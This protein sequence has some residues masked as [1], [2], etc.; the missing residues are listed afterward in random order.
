MADKT[1]KE[2]QEV[3]SKLQEQA[4]K[5]VVAERERAQRILKWLD[6]V[7]KKKYSKGELVCFVQYGHQK[8]ADERYF[9]C[10]YLN[11]EGNKF[12]DIST[13]DIYEMYDKGY[14]G[15]MLLKNDKP[16]RKT[17]SVNGRE[18]AMISGKVKGE[19]EKGEVYRY[20]KFDLG[21]TAISLPESCTG[22]R[23]R[24]VGRY[25][26]AQNLY[27]LIE[28]FSDGGIISGEDVIS[29]VAEGNRECI[30]NIHT[31]INGKLKSEQKGPTVNIQGDQINIA[32]L[33][34]EERDF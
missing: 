33:T 7:L 24:F 22:F 11:A 20:I 14:L 9:M 29:A 10:G 25:N 2:G 16:A 12:R 21:G 34:P 8:S 30:A 19:I 32:Q 31:V 26:K 4:R 23:D 27:A 28:R 15:D 13:G 17:L 1:R 3:V 5:D 6:D 18:F